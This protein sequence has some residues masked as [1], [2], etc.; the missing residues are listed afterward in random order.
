MIKYINLVLL[1]IFITAVLIFTAENPEL[2]SVKFLEFR[3]IKLP[4]SVIV[5]SAA[6]A[7]ILIGL[8][9]HFYVVYK[10]KKDLKPKDEKEKL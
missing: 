9:Y 3:S 2:V 10:I 7:G 5:F 4:I 6:I 1:V 8:I